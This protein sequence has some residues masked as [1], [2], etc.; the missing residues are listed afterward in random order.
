MIYKNDRAG[1]NL[2]SHPTVSPSLSS[3]HLSHGFFPSKPE[4][5]KLDGFVILREQ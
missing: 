2:R 3:H 1:K 5:S 4:I